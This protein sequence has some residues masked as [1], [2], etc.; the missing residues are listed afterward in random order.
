R[1]LYLHTIHIVF[2]VLYFLY[3][4]SFFFLI[5]RRPPRSTLFPY[6]TLFRSCMQNMIFMI[7]ISKYSTKIL[8]VRFRPQESTFTTMNWQT[9]PVLATEIATKLF[10]IRDG[11]AN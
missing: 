11:R 5:I 8:S 10:I 2:V 7:I 6:T 9:Q 1:V 3:V 4:A